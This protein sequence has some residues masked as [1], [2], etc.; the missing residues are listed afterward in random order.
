VC[1]APEA[2]RLGYASVLTA[3][4]ARSIVTRGEVPFL[5]IAASNAAARAVCERLGFEARTDVSFGVYRPG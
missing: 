2:R 1:T 4:V 3:E 5:H